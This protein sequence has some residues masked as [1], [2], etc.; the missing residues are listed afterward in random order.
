ML[1]PQ[2]GKFAEADD[3]LKIGMAAAETEE[4]DSELEE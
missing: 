2:K 4:N 1:H 3:A